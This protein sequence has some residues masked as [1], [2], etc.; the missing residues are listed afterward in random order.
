MIEQ[1]WAFFTLVLP[2]REW[3]RTSRW[4][5][6]IRNTWSGL[7]WRW[8]NMSGWV[9]DPC[10][11]ERQSWLAVQGRRVQWNSKR[12][13]QFFSKKGL[14]CQWLYQNHWNVSGEKNVYPYSNTREKTLKNGVKKGF[15]ANKFNPNLRMFQYYVQTHGHPPRQPS[16]VRHFLY[17][18][19][20]YNG[21]ICLDE[22]L[23]DA[24]QKE[25]QAEQQV[26]RE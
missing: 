20:N 15:I 7:G 25:T 26:V 2:Q 9:P 24:C 23:L 11:S 8:A 3:T 19:L 1:F 13:I 18:D 10:L 4:D 22:H 12:K 14:R 17:Y 21:V 5:Y 16:L 6:Y